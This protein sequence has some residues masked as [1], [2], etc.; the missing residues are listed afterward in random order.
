VDALPDNVMR[1]VGKHA[2]ISIDEGGVVAGAVYSKKEAIVI[3]TLFFPEDVKRITRFLEGRNLIVKTVVNTHWDVDHVLGNQFFG[4]VEIIA[5]DKTL[6]LMNTNGKEVLKSA[7]KSFPEL[8]EVYQVLP[9]K[10]FSDTH[11]LVIGESSLV[12]QHMPGHTSDSTIVYLPKEKL[13]F[14]GDVVID[15]PFIKNDG[16][17]LLESLYKISRMDIN[18][19]IQ[20]HGPI[21]GK[22]KVQS[23]I[24][25]LETTRKMVQEQIDSG[26]MKDQL[27]EISLSECLDE[28]RKNLPKAYERYIHPENLIKLRNELIE[29]Q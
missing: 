19:I 8:E 7:K 14:A 11:Q 4:S 9:T 3:D 6:S 29:S 27:E 23:D 12:L 10:T 1:F 15:L 5:H 28:P 16:Q 13:L 20:G 2:S 22:D 25:Y 21:C 24:R 17:K 18:I 26:K